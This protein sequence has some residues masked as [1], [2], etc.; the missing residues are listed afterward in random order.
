MYKDELEVIFQE[1]L[2]EVEGYEFYKIAA[3]NG[4]LSNKK[5]FM[6]LANEELK[7]VEYLRALFDKLK[8]SKDDD[9]KLA[10][11]KKPRSPNIYQWN[12]VESQYNSLVC[13]W[14]KIA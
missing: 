9:I 5:A 8:T 11:D 7:H 6:E 13:K 12:K 1:I 4:P 2:N 10:F 14:R 3:E